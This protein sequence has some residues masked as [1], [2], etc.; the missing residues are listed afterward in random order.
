M[1]K[2]LLIILLLVCA[3]SA[4][5]RADDAD[6]LTTKVSNLDSRVDD[7]EIKIRGLTDRVIA[8]ENP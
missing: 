7:L 8:L 1:A 5:S 2:N 4:P 6:E 3:T